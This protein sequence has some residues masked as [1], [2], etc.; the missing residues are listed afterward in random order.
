MAGTSPQS[1][2]QAKTIAFL[3]ASGSYGRDIPVH[4]VDTHISHIF[5]VGDRAYKLKR[6]VKLDYLDF[7][8]LEKRR[9]AC[10]TELR[11][12]RRTAPELYLDVQSVNQAPDGSIG[13]GDGEPIDWLVVMRRFDDDALLSAVA[14]RGELSQPLIYRLAD[15][16]AQFH[17][18]LHSVIIQDSHE[19]LRAI[20]EE[21]DRCLSDHIET[22]F[23]SFEVE[24]LLISSELLLEKL[25]PLLDVRGEAGHIRHCHGDLH[26]ANIC[27]W[28]GE[29]T[30][31]D[32]LEFNQEM[33]T[34][35][36]LYDIAFLLMDLCHR[37]LY[38]EAN[39]LL[40]RYLD[41]TGE[42][43]GIASIPLFLSMRA[44]IRAHVTATQSGLQTDKGK[45][46]K[47][48]ESA[49]HYLATALQLLH[50]SPARLIAIG[51]LSGTGKSTLA[52]LI[53][54]KL[55]SPIG[56]RLL[57]TDVLR[58]RMLGVAPEE[59]LEEQAYSAE[60][61]EKVY[62]GLMDE[63]SSALE[64]GF[65]VIADGVFAN[66]KMR[67]QI[68]GMAREQNVPFSGIW[69]EAP[70]EIL[71]RRVEKRKGDAS[72]ADVAVVQK[73]SNTRVGD[74][75]GW[76]TVDSSGS[77]EDVAAKIL[78]VL[79]DVDEPYNAG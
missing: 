35:D 10:L 38:P 77:P 25:A 60:Q 8:T 36:M 75:G 21:N 67:D 41:M 4:R 37:G 43:G 64:S 31:F 26:L 51:G 49:K 46:N 44:A 27:L 42:A 19:R 61:N 15:N 20:I 78:S 28:N 7:S 17:G 32:C 55:G 57:R 24:K 2:K 69:L 39:G 14:D 53:A 22:I 76:N 6:A 66:Q 23:P 71:K 34:I 48:A 74:L 11:L 56:A 70:V 16:I 45:R 13:F 54:P 3:E 30:L 58:K 12:N 33:A 5:L 62:A 59:H 9:Y 18:S 79:P 50:T 72:D 68:E 65:T 40:N 63:I 29:P 1:D 52:R 47:L 73:Q